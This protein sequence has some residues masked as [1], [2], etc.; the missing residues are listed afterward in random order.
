M[1]LAADSEGREQP[2][3]VLPKAITDR[4]DGHR[5]LRLPDGYYKGPPAIFMWQF[6]A[7]KAVG[8]LNKC[9]DQPAGQSAQ[10]FYQAVQASQESQ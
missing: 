9:F 6:Y 4:Q 3:T 10:R 7:G 5:Y 1:L 8:K 2:T